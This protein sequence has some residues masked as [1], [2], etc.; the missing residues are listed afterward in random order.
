MAKYLVSFKIIRFFVDVFFNY[1]L[2]YFF[3]KKY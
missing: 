2:F 1:F 3:S